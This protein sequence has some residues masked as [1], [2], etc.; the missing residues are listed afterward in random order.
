MNKQIPVTILTGFLGSGKTTLLNYILTQN[1]GKKI[2][3]I[4]NEFG[5]IGIDNELVIN[6]EEEIFEMNNGCICC[7]VR[8]DLIRILGKLANKKDKIDYVIIETTGL[9]DPAPVAQTFFVDDDIKRDYRLD[10]I[11]TLID[12]KHF[13]QHIDTDRE[14]LE[15]IAFA[16][17]VLINKI[18]LVTESQLTT[19][20]ARVK[21]IN[22]QTKLHKTTKAHVDLTH[23]LDIGGFNFDR[24][25]EIKSDFLAPEYSFEWL[26]LTKLAKGIYTINI[27][28]GP[29]ETLKLGFKKFVTE[30]NLESLVNHFTAIM[31]ERPT[32]KKI[33]QITLKDQHLLNL[34]LSKESY[35]KL[36]LVIEE[37]CFLGMSTQHHPDEFSLTMVNESGKL[38]EFDVQENFSGGHEHDDEI[39]SVG[40]EVEGELNPV[41]FDKWIGNLLRTK[42]ADIFRSKGIL[43]LSG[44]AK[45]YIFQGVHMLQEGQFDSN[46]GKEKKNQ[47]I[48]IGKNL[49]R[50]ELTKGFMKCLV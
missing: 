34:N 31:S 14:C 5:E 32:A 35:Y 50:N 11:V 20:E 48:F 38:I 17:V 9:A 45:R 10:G 36:N 21:T 6:A 40:I 41:L 28:Q 25:M 43:A 18:D 12:A 1:H 42:G 22:N 19:I 49:D 27:K 37:D 3:V 33:K 29:D 23:I 39:S 16:D 47:I 4:E 24:A 13:S 15:Q 26:A 30:V 2:A 44:E 46:W 8:G 7:T